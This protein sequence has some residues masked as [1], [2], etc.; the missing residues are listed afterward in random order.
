VQGLTVTGMEIVSVRGI[1]TIAAP[2][3]PYAKR[4]KGIWESSLYK[5]YTFLGVPLVSWGAAVS[6]VYLGILFCFVIFTPEMRDSNGQSWILYGIVWI[7][8]IFWYFYG[9][10]RSKQVGVDGGMTHAELPPE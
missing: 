9:A 4:S 6:L 1:T 5:T 10:A 3:F 2:I 7:S 8:G